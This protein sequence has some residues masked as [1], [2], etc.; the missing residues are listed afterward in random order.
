MRY[1]DADSCRRN[2]AA[3]RNY[4]ADHGKR[5]HD[6]IYA[7]VNGLGILLSAPPKW[8][9]IVHGVGRNI[10]QGAV[11]KRRCTAIRRNGNRPRIT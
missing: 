9:G 3:Q 1:I 2:S 6:T 7:G 11:F 10:R 8:A 5:L 4:Y